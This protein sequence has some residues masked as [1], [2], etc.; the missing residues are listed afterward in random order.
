M[1]HSAR[2]FKVR[3]RAPS[4]AWISTA[5]A[6]N[7][8][9][10]S[11]PGILLISKGADVD[12]AAGVCVAV[13]AVVATGDDVWVGCTGNGVEGAAQEKRN[14]T[15]IFGRAVKARRF[16][17]INSTQPLKSGDTIFCISAN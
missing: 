4:S 17:I 2:R 16:W 10:S 14:R 9:Q 12:V 6:L 11:N 5:G 8:A 3:S 7:T 1:N 13:A 15:T